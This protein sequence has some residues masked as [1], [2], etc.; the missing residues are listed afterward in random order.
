MISM[1]LI[2]IFPRNI[3]SRARSASWSTFD[4]IQLSFT[5]RSISLVFPTPGNNT[6]DLRRIRSIRHDTCPDLERRPDCRD[7][8]SQALLPPQH[9]PNGAHCFARRRLLAFCRGYGVRPCKRFTAPA[10]DLQQRLQV[11]GSSVNTGPVS[12]ATACRAGLSGDNR[13]S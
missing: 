4:R 6:T 7:H 12:T 3:C 1:S 13:S 11:R 5:S 8:R 2:R 9:R 10:H